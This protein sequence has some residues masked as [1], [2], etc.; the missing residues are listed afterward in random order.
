MATGLR[1]NLLDI[2]NFGTAEAAEEER[3]NTTSGQIRRA[4]KQHATIE[5]ELRVLQ[6]S[7]C[8]GGKH[9]AKENPI[10]AKPQS[11][12]ERG[13]EQRPRISRKRDCPETSSH[14][15]TEGPNNRL[16]SEDRE[17][18]LLDAN[19]S[20]LESSW[21]AYIG[22]GWLESRLLSCLRDTGGEPRGRMDHHW[23]WPVERGV[24]WHRDY[25]YKKHVARQCLFSACWKE[26]AENAPS[27]FSGELGEDTQRAPD[28]ILRSSDRVDFHVH[29][30]MLK[31]TS[32]FFD[33]M[34]AVSQTNHAGD[35]SRNGL[36]VFCRYTAH[37]C[38][39]D[40]PISEPWVTQRV[41]IRRHS[42]FN[43]SRA[44][45]AQFNHN[46]PAGNARSVIFPSWD[47]QHACIQ[48]EK[49]K[50]DVKATRQPRG[51]RWRP[52]QRKY[53]FMRVLK[54]LKEM[55][56]NCVLVDALAHRMFAIARLL[57]SP[58]LARK[59]AIRTLR[60]DVAASAKF[61]EMKLLDWE[62]A[63]SLF[64]FHRACGKAAVKVLESCVQGARRL[65]T[66]LRITVFDT[67]KRA[68]Q[69]DAFVWWNWEAAHCKGCAP[70]N[71]K[72]DDGYPTTL[73]APWFRAFIKALSAKILVLPSHELVGQMAS[74]AT[75]FVRRDI[76]ACPACSP[77]AMR[78]LAV[79]A[80]QLAYQDHQ[81]LC[82]TQNFSAANT[83][84]SGLRIHGATGTRRGSSYSIP[85]LRVEAKKSS[86]LEASESAA[87]LN[88]TLPGRSIQ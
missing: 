86:V 21:I 31:F 18:T 20:V 8:T 71:I 79:F 40:Q 87:T 29:K 49:K 33:G 85:P 78:D 81:L 4:V 56:E 47:G 38:R 63:Q 80:R 42:S 55:L 62:T 19:T 69:D 16:F 5:L 66:E 70:S 12:V 83:Q 60:L 34:L 32:D 53:Q 10:L 22:Q 24:D 3:S 37:A 23:M 58:A 77:R 36:S 13:L 84:I 52:K 2:L 17:A 35:L 68:S 30:E 61:P 48:T 64:D 65:P 9:G 59:A 7:M 72:G 11:R 6:L 82:E 75:D 28:F 57:E 76:N 67:R 45:A 41:L 39:V 25:H 50:G 15:L 43:S 74:D 14:R 27:P 46:V 44:S 73:A 54:V 26:N 1:S 88:E 51:I